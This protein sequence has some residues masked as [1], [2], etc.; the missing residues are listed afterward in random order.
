MTEKPVTLGTN[1]LSERELA[2]LVESSAAINAS[3]D[4]GATLQAIARAA[5]AVLDA[6]ASSVLLHDRRR[7]KLVFEAAF[8]E[9]GDAL[10]GQ[11]MPADQG[12]AGRVVTTGMAVIINNVR[13][14]PAHFRGFDDRSKFETKELIAAPMRIGADVIGVVEVLNPRADRQFSDRD[15]ELL[16]VFANLAA[17]SASNAQHHEGVKRENRRLREVAQPDSAV[18][19]NSEALRSVMQ[20]CQRVAATHATVLLLGETGT[21]KEVC[22]RTIHARSPRRD[23]AFVAINCAALPE[24]LLESELFGHE[25]GAFTGAAGRK[26]GRFELADGGTLFLDEIG[27]IS[28]STQVKLLRVLQEREFVRVGGTNAIACD[29]RIITATNRDLKAAIDDGTFREDLFY[30]LNVFPIRVPPVR[31]RVEDI[32]LLVEHFVTLSVRELAMRPVRVSEE[33]ISLLC[34]Y[35]WPGNVREMRNV[36][37][38]AVLLCDGDEITPAHLPKEVSGD[39]D[40]VRMGSAGASVEA[41][42]RALIVKALEEHEWNQTRAAEALG[43]SRDNLRYRLRK[44]GIQRPKTS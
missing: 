32:T 31:E 6:E 5:A 11:E 13:Q 3:L 20:L 2:A 28:A 38:R 4:L 26:L 1:A 44:Y 18:I 33:A 43:L 29:V 23:R 27:D 40:R 35:R 9:T 14:D 41:Y 36:I 42:E 8:G 25:A 15:S 24:T 10:L 21:G 19:G 39:A 37:E 22:A 7:N 30:R 17:I 12:F 16:Q 34:A